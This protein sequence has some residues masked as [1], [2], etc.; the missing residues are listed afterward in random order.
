MSKVAVCGGIKIDTEKFLMTPEMRGLVEKIVSDIQEQA[1]S[2]PNSEAGAAY[3]SLWR[4]ISA[5]YLPKHEKYMM[6]IVDACERLH[7]STTGASDPLSDDEERTLT[8]FLTERIQ[9]WT[10]S[11]IKWSGPYDHAI[12]SLII[13][14][15]NEKRPK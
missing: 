4:E 5:K 9:G 12:Y 8:E 11:G 15:L 7:M 10:P 3:D 14:T 2:L 1:I 6:R 13:Q